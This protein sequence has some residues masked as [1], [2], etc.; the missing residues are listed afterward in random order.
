MSIAKLIDALL[1]RYAADTSGVGR[2]LILSYP[3]FRQYNEIPR[4][5]GFRNTYIFCARI[6][7]PTRLTFSIVDSNECNSSKLNGASFNHAP[8]VWTN[9]LCT[10]MYKE[11]DTY[12]IRP[13]SISHC[14]LRIWIHMCSSDD[15]MGIQ[16]HIQ[17]RTSEQQ[18]ELKKASRS[19]VYD[20]S[21]NNHAT[22]ET[23]RNIR[24]MLWINLIGF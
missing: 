4:F 13:I 7:T 18:S 23:I 22:N 15:S 9:N 2:S 19:L 10:D 12:H 21:I 3:L 14:P 16:M 6:D 11:S 17:A 1:I 20:V 5:P 8:T 24:M